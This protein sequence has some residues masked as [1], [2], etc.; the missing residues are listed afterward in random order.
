[1]F[2]LGLLRG[3]SG[4]VVGATSGRELTDILYDSAFQAVQG[5]P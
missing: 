3:T 2:R 5:L 1:M 4:R